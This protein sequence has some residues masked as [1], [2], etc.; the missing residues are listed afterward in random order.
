MYQEAIRFINDITEEKLI[1]IH[2][3]TN[4]EKRF[5]ANCIEPIEIEKEINIIFL[6]KEYSKIIIKSC[7]GHSIG[8]SIEP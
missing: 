8:L 3:S 4:D 6:E 5:Y 1:T 2:A 7:L